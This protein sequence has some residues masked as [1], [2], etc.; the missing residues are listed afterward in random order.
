MISHRLKLDP[1]PTNE[2]VSISKK[3]SWIRKERNKQGKVLER[4]RNIWLRALPISVIAERQYA[5]LTLPRGLFLQ[6]SGYLTSLYIMTFRSY[7]LIG[8]AGFETANPGSRDL[9]ITWKPQRLTLIKWIKEKFLKRGGGGREVQNCWKSLTSCQFNWNWIGPVM[10]VKRY[11]ITKFD[12]Y[13][14]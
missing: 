2:V 11:T 8:W 13:E 5:I 4:K 14:P 3:M 9:H 7:K 1:L 12:I 6:A 10:L